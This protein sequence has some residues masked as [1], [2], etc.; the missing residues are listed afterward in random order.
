MNKTKL[1]LSAGIAAIWLSAATGCVPALKQKKDS[2]VE[3][4]IPKQYDLGAADQ[5]SSAQLGW[6][7]LFEDPNLRGLIEQALKNNQELHIL[8]Q[9]IQIAD[10]EVLARRGEYLPKAGVGVDAGFN[11]P[12][13]YEQ[14]GALPGPSNEAEEGQSGMHYGLGLYASWEV[15]IWNKLRNA[16]KSAALNYLSTIEGRSFAVTMLISELA[17]SY[18]ELMALDNQLEVLRSNIRLQEDG[19]E[20]IKLQKEAAKVTELAVQRFEAEVLKNKSLQYDLLQQITETENRINQLVGRYPQPIT[21][22]S[23]GFIDL[24]PRA[25]TA[26]VPSKLLAN[27]PDVRQAELKLKAAKLDIEVARATFYPSLVI[28][29]GVGYRSGE[30]KSLFLTPESLILGTVANL[31]TPLLN[32]NTIKANYFSA[33]ASQIQ[34]AYSYER[35]V[36]NAYVECA[37]QLALI[38]NLSKS[39]ELRRQQVEKLT[40]SIEISNTLF[41][42]ARADYLE[43][44]TTRREALESQLEL[45]ETKKRQMIAVVNTYKALGGGWRTSAS[46]KKPAN[47]PANKPAESK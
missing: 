6:E 25:I 37:N 9:E 21:R 47:K 45:V 23:Q 16:T 38:D 4:L 34:A 32:R 44:L 11:V 12:G 20:V 15:D 17:S 33:N 27:R 14:E 41:Q 5:D 19:L 18:Y 35:T 7:Q 31:F 29:A 10:N 1:I 8:S 46:A 39:Y 36:L 30:I 26:G 43:V 2:E 40:S 42:S 3:S 13:K 28:D 22:Q 24:M